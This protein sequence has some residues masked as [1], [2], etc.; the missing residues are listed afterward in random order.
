MVLG[1]FRLGVMIGSGGRDMSATCRGNVR[2]LQ[3]VAKTPL[4]F[5]SYS[6]R[7]VENFLPVFASPARQKRPICPFF[8]A[9]VLSILF[10]IFAP[11][12][13]IV[14]GVCSCSRGGHNWFLIIGFDVGFDN[15]FSR[16][17]DCSNFSRGCAG[18]DAIFFR[19]LRSDRRRSL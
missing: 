18:H 8:F 17:F 15:W 4:E 16:C 6:L 12:P 2:R 3:A 13:L 19:L 9:V 14:G 11:L 1:F 10:S 5:L 7:P